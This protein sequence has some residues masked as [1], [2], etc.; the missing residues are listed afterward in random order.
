LASLVAHVG[1]NI[2]VG[3]GAINCKIKTSYET[4]E[5]HLFIRA[6]GKAGLPVTIL[7]CMHL[8]EVIYW[9]L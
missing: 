9:S 3:L 7:R 4:L 2:W 8:Q 1:Y 5:E 6:A